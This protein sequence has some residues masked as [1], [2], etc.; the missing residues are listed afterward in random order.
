MLVP[1]QVTCEFAPRYLIDITASSVDP[2]I[3]IVFADDG[4]L[5]RVMRMALHF[6]GWNSTC[7]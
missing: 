4:L 1:A 5:V 2:Y 7:Q 6:T 3:H